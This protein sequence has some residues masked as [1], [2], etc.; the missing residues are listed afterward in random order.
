MFEKAGPQYVVDKKNGLSLE[1]TGPYSF[2][3]R[4]NQ[5]SATLSSEPL[6]DEKGIYCVC[7]YL[8][9]LEQW[10]EPEG[11]PVNEAAR[12]K[13]EEDVVS[14]LALLDIEVEVE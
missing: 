4:D 10:D 11:A 1:A 2:L 9:D 14:A 6:L 3:Y 5:R 8:S 13:I 12:K 7:L